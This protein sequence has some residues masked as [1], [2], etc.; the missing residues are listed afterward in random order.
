MSSTART[1]ADVLAASRRADSLCKRQRTLDVVRSTLADRGHITFT[2]VARTARVST[3]LVHAEGVREYIEAAIRQQEHE[4][5]V[6]WSDGRQASIAE[7]A[8]ANRR[9]EQDVAQLQPLRK[10]VEEVE[11]DLGAA[12]TSPRK[13]IRAENS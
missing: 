6:A 1:P 10:R 2:T 12:H 5:V 3:W 8:N 7:L 9:L 4:P 13:M 11:N